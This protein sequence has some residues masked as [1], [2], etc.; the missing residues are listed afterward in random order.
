MVNKKT[1]YLVAIAVFVVLVTA[2]HHLFLQKQSPH[3]V[4]EEIYY[5]PILFGALFFGLKGAIL[6]YLFASLSYLPFFFGSWAAT[7]LV[8]I[9]RLLHLLFTGVFAFLAGFF[10]DRERKRQKELDKERYLAGI[11]QVA[12]TIVHDLKNPLIT[13]LGFARRIREGKGNTESNAEAITDS[14]QHMQ[15]IVNDVLDFSKPIKLALKEEDLRNVIKQ[16]SDSCITKAEQRGVPLFI[17]TP[18]HPL[19]IVID[20]FN[21][22]RALSN[23]INNAIE[24]SDKGQEV[25]V[26][27]EAKKDYL[28]VMIKDHGSGMDKET[29]ENIFTPFYTKKSGGTGLGLPIAKKIIEGHKGKIRID[30]KPGAGTEVIIEFLYRKEVEK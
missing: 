16:V 1:Y 14:A 24:A 6:I 3:V 21:M 30:S 25:K 12:T 28:Y 13:I 8:L 5:I 20:S 18:I 26:T 10:V 11:G 19:N 27:A 23:L 17:D 22:Q 9:N 15:R 7:F 4:L 29:L 2:L